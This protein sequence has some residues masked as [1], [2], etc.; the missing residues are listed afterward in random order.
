MRD[1]R[2]NQSVVAGCNNPGKNKITVSFTNSNRTCANI[3]HTVQD[4]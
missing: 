4:R 3:S 2:F 1:N